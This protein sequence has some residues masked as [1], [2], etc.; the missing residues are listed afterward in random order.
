M[1]VAQR[2]GEDDITLSDSFAKLYDEHLSNIY[3]YINYRVGDVAVAEDMTSVVFEKALA[4]FRS[5]NRE[6]AA[7]QTWLLSIAR[8]TLTDY[9]R[10]AA[11]NQSVPLE[12]TDGV[13]SAA[14]S[15]EEEV[16]RIEEEERL[17]LCLGRLGHQEQEIISLKFGAEITNRRIAIMLSLSESNVGV[18]LFRALRK[19]KDCFM[20]WLNGKRR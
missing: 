10:K 12:N 18:I 6:K 7:P 13:A 16:E 14:P 9:F 4:G 11:R 5:Y 3:R 20:E 17:R 15:P 1:T 2:S 8:N 19:L